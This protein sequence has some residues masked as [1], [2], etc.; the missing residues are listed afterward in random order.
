MG[1]A[2]H[3]AMLIMGESL[4]FL[5]RFRRTFSEGL[6]KIIY[7][8][9][10]RFL[11]IAFLLFLFAPPLRVKA[12]TIDFWHVYYNAERV[13]SFH[14][15]T[16]PS[17]QLSRM[18]VQP[19]DTIRVYYFRDTPCQNCKTWITMTDS[20]GTQTI[21]G[22]G[23]GAFQAI[24]FPAEGL[25]NCRSEHVKVYYHEGESIPLDNGFLVLDIRLL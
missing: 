5:R 12:D 4:V 7:L 22:N 23:R 10:M 24:T 16:Y 11:S 21:L 25:F 2:L 8:W 1:N 18:D 17:M 15:H 14:Q 20:A 6:N 9:N 13:A 3:P 19:G